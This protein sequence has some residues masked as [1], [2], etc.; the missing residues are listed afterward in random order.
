MKST[1]LAFFAFLC[2]FLMFAA[3]EQT[4]FGIAFVLLC[5]MVMSGYM[6]V[7]TDKTKK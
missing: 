5:L 2:S 7:H 3:I 4:S 1:L 6:A